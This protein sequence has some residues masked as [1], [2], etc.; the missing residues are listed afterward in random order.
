MVVDAEQTD[1]LGLAL[2]RGPFRSLTAARD[3]IEQARGQGA[4]VSPLADI[5]ETA[6]A[7]PSA[8]PRSANRDARRTAPRPPDR[9]GTPD[10]PREPAWLTELD[11]AER[12]RARALLRR[13][14]QAG[15]ADATAV[16]RAELV[17]DR[18]AVAQLAIERRLRTLVEAAAS[19]AES[20]ARAVADALIHGDDAALGVGWR[21]TDTSGRPIRKLGVTRD[22]A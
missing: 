13:L 2:V 5:V 1:D 10:E 16:A 3:A 18:P 21:L 12:R 9:A 15:V 17:Q 14:E 11:V 6:K 8:A 22:G 7:R 19:D 4:A 20:V